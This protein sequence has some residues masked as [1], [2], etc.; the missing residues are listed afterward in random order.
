[1]LGHVGPGRTTGLSV[2][3]LSHAE[4]EADPGVQA[5][6]AWAFL[7]PPRSPGCVLIAE[8]ARSSHVQADQPWG[9]KHHGPVPRGGTHR[10]HTSLIPRAGSP[11]HSLTETARLIALLLRQ[12]ST[13]G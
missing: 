6:S 8:G 5:G 4:T 7:A 11:V 12:V 9:R 13:K 1:M 10:G 2:L 3:P